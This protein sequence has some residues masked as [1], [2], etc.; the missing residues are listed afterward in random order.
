[1]RSRIV[2]IA[3]TRRQFM[4]RMGGDVGRCCSAHRDSGKPL[5]VLKISLA[6]AGRDSLVT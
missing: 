4:A 3:R 2:N 5:I 1:M 6:A